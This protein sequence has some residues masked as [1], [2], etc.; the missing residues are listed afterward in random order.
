VATTSR[1]SSTQETGSRSHRSR[2]SVKETAAK[3]REKLTFPKVHAPKS[4]Q[5]PSAQKPPSPL[6]AP[7]PANIRSVQDPVLRK[8]SSS[9]TSANTIHTV[10]GKFRLACQRLQALRNDAVA[11]AGQS[12]ATEEERRRTAHKLLP[13][14]C[15]QFSRRIA[16]TRSVQNDGT[17]EISSAHESLRSESDL[18]EGI[19]GSETETST[20]SLPIQHSP[21]IPLCDKLHE[22]RQPH[23]YLVPGVHYGNIKIVIPQRLASLQPDTSS[24]QQSQRL[25]EV[26]RQVELAPCYGLSR[27]SSGIPATMDG[28]LSESDLGNVGN[29]N[30][31][32]AHRQASHH[33]PP[34][35]NDAKDETASQISQRRRDLYRISL[36]GKSHVSLRRLQKFSLEDSRRRQGIARDWS[37]PRKRFVAAVACFSTATVGILIGIYA[38]L[39]PS[40]QYYIADYHHNVILGNVVFYLGLAIPTFFFWPLPLLH[41]R[42]PYILSSLILAMPLLFPQA[43][44]V[45]TVR[46]PF[47]STWRW[48]LL[49]SRAFMGFVLGFANMNFHSIL[50]DLFGASLMSGNPHQELVDETDTRRHGGGMGVWL[51]IWTWCF[52]GSLG[53]GFMVGAAII[54][55]LNPAWG[56][57]VSIIIIAVAML[58]N[59]L[60]PEVRRAPFRRSITEVR[61]G[62]EVSR[63]VARG[64][65]MMH[66]VKTG[67]KWWGQ[68]VYH[69]VCLSLE[70]LK[71]PGFAITALY[72]GWIYCQ[73][74]L[75]I[76]LLGSLASRA[77]KLRSTL[78][79]VCL[80]CVALGALIGVPF[81]KANILSRSRH[82]QQNLD[83]MT[84][85]KKMVWTSHF[86]RRTVFT[87]LLP[88]FGIAYAIASNGPPTPLAVPVVLAA[89][90]GFLSCLA[91]AECNGLLMET[92]DC[93]DLQ[94]STGQRTNCSSFPRVTSAFAIAHSLSF[95]LAAGATGIGGV[96]QRQLGQRTATGAVSAILVVLTL[97]F[98]GVLIR[99]KDVQ[100]VPFVKVEAMEKWREVRRASYFR[101]SVVHASL[102]DVQ[103]LNEDEQE[104][105]RNAEPY[106]PMD[107]MGFPT[108]ATRRVN[109]LEMGALTRWSLIRQK[110]K[111]IDNHV[112]LN[113][114]AISDA[115]EAATGVTLSLA[116][117][118][119][120]SSSKTSRIGSHGRYERECVMEQPLR[121]EAV[122]E[123]NDGVEDG[124]GVGIDYDAREARTKS[125]PTPR[126]GSVT[127]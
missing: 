42:R 43:I 89:A 36:R 12:I 50:M 7:F 96:A 1:E 5:H 58:L 125:K 28:A 49:G 75:V 82:H 93:S 120:R 53:I 19:L 44:A 10:E 108:H 56:F 39:V 54:N 41:G 6:L 13:H 74:V 126:V 98:S 47:V 55:T 67:P 122:E 80:C 94:R 88:L 91:M 37:G 86:I 25:N 30:R 105:L 101:R 77:Y 110:N 62:T 29:M 81:Q 14:G 102:R 57:Y 38:G 99:F 69:G 46:S 68:E 116:T 97:L 114:L 11:L 123:E 9:S 87:I 18:E 95:V 115:V 121:E 76:V 100:I 2:L 45:G 113:R 117:S 32:V 26:A 103:K 63:R 111:L 72:L 60:S 109:V 65:I 84:H 40:I 107:V 78:V 4:T 61:K 35:E 15:Q 73:F 64:E 112:N 21:T 48:C 83:R 24:P 8:T 22:E 20:S 51:G 66:R 17:L 119:P 52:T 104:A 16:A 118:V 31:I 33:T 71:Q 79:G 124:I 90:V 127:P 106:R 92:F 27:S 85:D 3:L 23:R 59:V 70:M 34:V